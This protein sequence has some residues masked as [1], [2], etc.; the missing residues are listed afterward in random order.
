MNLWKIAYRN[1]SRQKR[2]SNLLA[3]AIAFGVMMIILVNSLT[4]GLIKTTEKNFESALGGHIYL[5]GEVLLDSGKVA[6]QIANPEVLDAVI[7]QFSDS[8]AESQKRSTI[9]GNFI[10]RSKS[11][12]GILYGVHWDQE[13]S[14]VDSL[15][16]LEGSLDR[17]REKGT[18]VLPQETAKDLGVELNEEI[19][20]SLTTVTGQANVG[21]FTIVAITKDTLGLGFSTAYAD[22]GYINEL[23]GLAPDEYQSYNL[24]LKDINQI[25]SISKEIE[26]AI[27]LQGSTLKPKPDESES[28]MSQGGMAGAMFGSDEN[29]EVW[30]GTRFNVGNLNDFMDMVAQIVAILNGIA[31]GVFFIMLLITMVGLMN[32]FRMIMIERTREIGTMRAIGMQ[33][34]DI[35][36]LFLLE[37]LI[38]A[39]RGV[40][41][42]IA[43]EL[44]VATIIKMIRF[45]DGS[46]FALILDQ[47]HVAV[48]VVFSN[49][50][51]ITFIIVVITLLAVWSPARKAAR[52]QPAD[53]LRA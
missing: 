45:A 47:G 31:L 36:K 10:F 38:L 37:G 25:N 9:T 22:I 41:F 30:S 53:A 18:I 19:L 17:I 26:D 39:L 43:A 15:E 52:L 13:Q 49:M 7:P 3:L 32:T 28:L 46:P 12:T 11:T 34:K 20:I 8:I 16:I 5:T 40:V 4:Q 6:N 35:S 21:E 23:V 29:E 50:V 1:V 14:L 44:V 27:V 33:K 51:M 48:P 2:R 24:V 42:G